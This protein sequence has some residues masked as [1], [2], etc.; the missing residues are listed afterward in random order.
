MVRRAIAAYMGLV[1]FLDHNVGTILS[2]LEEAGLSGD[3]RVI[4]STDPETRA[5]LTKLGIPVA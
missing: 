4:Y 5:F 1:T 3:T 2:A